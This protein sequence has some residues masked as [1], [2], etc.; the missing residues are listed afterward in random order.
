MTNSL[1]CSAAEIFTLGMKTQTNTITV[2][3]TTRGALSFVRERVLP[4]GWKYRICSQVVFNPDGSLLTDKQGNY[5][6]GIGIA[7]DFY[8]PDFYYSFIHDEDAALD[9][10]IEKLSKMIQNK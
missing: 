4:N 10:S 9:S 2:G 1:T 8:V 3:D 7:P 6:E 5:I